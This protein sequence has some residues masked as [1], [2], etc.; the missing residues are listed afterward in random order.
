MRLFLKKYG[1]FVFLFFF[2]LYS[3]LVAYNLFFGDSIVNYGFSYAILRGEVPYVDY[4]LVVPLF[5]PFLYAI[6]LLISKSFLF[7]YIVQSL[8]VVFLFVL[9]YLLLKDKWKLLLPVVFLGFPIPIVTILFPGYNFILLFL[10]LLVVCCE[11][12]QKNDYL[13]GVLLGLMILTKHTLGVLFILPSLLYIRYPK[14]LGKRFLGLVIPLFIFLVYLM[15]SH[16]FWEF[17][18]LCILGLFDFAS[19]NT[20]MMNYWLLLPF[21]GCLFYV[22]FC[23]IKHR[24]DVFPYYV[25]VASLFSYPLFDSYHLSFFL[26]LT[27]CLFLYYS[28]FSI[29]NLSCSVLVFLLFLGGMWTFITFCFRGG[30]YQFQN[31]PNYPLRYVSSSDQK[32]YRKVQGFIKEWK[33]EVVLFGL[34]TEN[35][36]YKITND[37]DITYFDLPNYGNYGYQGGELMIKK[38]DELED[39]SVVLIDEGALRDDNY[40]QQYH[41][42]LANYVI[43]NYHKLQ[44]VGRYQAYVKEK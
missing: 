10:L 16:S 23:L 40:N 13:I 17:I 8:L 7:Y 41:K 14:K 12:Y 43:K 3:L 29:P 4:N 19:S 25:L 27:M 42:E 28:K 26:F 5:S 44:K 39:F 37:L 30:D 36:F 11:V 1:Q 9:C 6:F 22:L 21:L 33:G 2:V 32:N 24:K 20:T 35:Y 15:V 31:Y 38:F 34:G 18:N